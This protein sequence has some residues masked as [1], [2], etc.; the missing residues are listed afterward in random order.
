L[1]ALVGEKSFDAAEAKLGPQ[2]SVRA[3]FAL[4]TAG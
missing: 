2:Q 3:A 1:P 4:L